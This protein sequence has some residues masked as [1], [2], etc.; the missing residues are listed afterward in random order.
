MSSTIHPLNKSRHVSIRL[1]DASP[2][3]HVKTQ[4]MVPVV[5]HEFVRLAAEYPLGFVKNT[6]TGQFQPVA[7]LG[8]SPG[9]N[10]FFSAS[11]WRS[12]QVPGFIT[13]YPLM[14]TPDIFNPDQLVVAINESSNLIGDGNL[15]FTEQGDETPYLQQRK[16][17][18]VDY[19]EK[20]LSSKSIVD[21][22]AKNKLLKQQSINVQLNGQNFV[23]NGVYVIDEQMLQQLNHESF[24][25]LRDRGLLPAIY[26]QLASIH[27]LQK[28]VKLK[29]DVLMGT[30]G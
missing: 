13:H 1:R 6:E 19:Y 5:L 16:Q 23:I 22:L 20:D 3:E 7:I 8:L 28:L 29:A 30:I 18:L 2:F 14:L 17:S 25:E 11:G 9:E 10:L 26:A 12:G 27:Q 15:L 21:F 24:I 4:H